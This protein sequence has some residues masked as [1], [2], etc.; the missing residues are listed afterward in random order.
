MRNI[1]LTK[2]LIDTLKP[3]AHGKRANY[4]DAQ[5]QNLLLRGRDKCTRTFCYRKTVDGI[6]KVFT[7]GRYPSMSLEEA[8][9]RVMQMES[10]GKLPDPLQKPKRAWKKLLLEA[11]I[12]NLRLHDLR[13]SLA[14]QMAMNNILCPPVFA[15][16]CRNCR[17]HSF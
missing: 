2:R 17:E 14:S 16:K 8:R 4:F 6:E 10:A 1:Q 13:R 9:S 3:L 5:T 7:L 11:G 15:Y 12:E